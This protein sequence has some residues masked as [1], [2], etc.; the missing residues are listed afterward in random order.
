MLVL[1]KAL[2]L[3]TRFHLKE[4]KTTTQSVVNHCQASVCRIH[5]SDNVKVLRNREFLVI[6]RKC[7]RC[8]SIIVFNEH[9]K[10]TKNLA[11][12]A[13]VNLVDNKEIF[14]LRICLRLLTEA[15]EHALFELKACSA[16][17]VAH[18]EVFV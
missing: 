1:D 6:V 7:S 8:T 5:H 16:R 4:A 18:H 14:C 2:S 9:Q 12:I 13:T 15:I 10:F 11:Q 17:L 3:K